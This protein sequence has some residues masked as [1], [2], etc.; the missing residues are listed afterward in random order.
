MIALFK[1]LWELFKVCAGLFFFVVCVYRT[2]TG[3]F[4]N[5]TLMFMGWLLFMVVAQN[6]SKLDVV[7]EN[8][9]VLAK[10]IAG[11]D[12][13]TEPLHSILKKCLIIK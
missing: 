13:D 1:L 12:P 4:S 7:T 3:N 11:E 9:K 5:E 2:Y 8:Q 10:G 6:S